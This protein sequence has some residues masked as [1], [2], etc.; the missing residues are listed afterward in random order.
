MDEQIVSLRRV[1]A[2][3]QSLGVPSNN[4]IASLRSQRQ[5]KKG[6]KVNRY[7]G[8][9]L[10]F[11]RCVIER[12]AGRDGQ[13]YPPWQPECASDPGPV[14]R[15]PR[16]AA[17]LSVPLDCVGTKRSVYRQVTSFWKLPERLTARDAAERT[18]LLL[19]FRGPLHVPTLTGSG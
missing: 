5:K 19:C 15:V 4:E 6:L 10:I 9:S 18:S 2:T 13:I 17:R 11:L 7:K 8:N 3:K 1:I 16:L 14:A 12:I